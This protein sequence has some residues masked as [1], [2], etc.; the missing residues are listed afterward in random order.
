MDSL[1]QKY[2]TIWWQYNLNG[3]EKILDDIL[4][5]NPQQPEALRNKAFAQYYYRQ[6]YSGALESIQKAI[7]AEPQEAKNYFVQG[8]ILFSRA[9]YEQAA[10]S[11]S[12]AIELD[13][14]NADYC[15][16]LAKTCLRL[17][18]KDEAK[19]ELETAVR[20][21]PYL[22]EANNLLHVAYVEGGEYDQAYRI[23]K[24]QYLFDE[25]GTSSYC[26]GEWNSLYQSAIMRDKREPD[27]HCTMG[28]LYERLLLYDEAKMEFEKARQQAPD[29]D[30]MFQS[31]EKVSKFIIFRETLKKTLDEFY[32]Q[33]AVQ[34]RLKEKDLLPR[35]VPIYAEIAGL[36]PDIRK[37]RKHNKG[38]LNK[39]NGRIEKKFHVIIHYGYID[40]YWGGLFGHVTLD[41]MREISQWGKTGKLRM[42]VLKN[43]VSNGFNSWYWNYQGQNGGWTTSGFLSQTKEFFVVMDPKY[44]AAYGRWE[45]LNDQNKRSKIL[46]EDKEKEEGFIDRPPL[47]VFYS[48]WLGNQLKLKAMD[49]AIQP[50]KD[51]SLDEQKAACIRLLLDHYFNTSTVIHE[52]QHALDSR[53]WLFGFRQ[54]ELE[55]RAKL[56]E[57]CYG[58][59]PHLSLS[60]ILSQDIGNNKLS[61]GRAV[62]MLFEDIS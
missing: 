27:Y 46:A 12:R 1:M 5:D 9:D 33:Q 53:H 56:S 31:F 32:R 15:L 14:A 34:G 13:S 29:D 26:P 38:W 16:S 39:V 17:N 51:C 48:S 30:N 19:R 60:D 8:D 21:N 43:M 28:Q 35:L 58:R 25:S 36:F 45:L 3:S 10:R 55:Y 42:V 49:E 4:K 41:T 54:W 62:T 50:Y 20:L 22:L 18:K 52:G 47:D 2:N 37:T 24:S 44:G 61:H 59:M 40:G 23:W 11:Y 7:G 57:N 6:N